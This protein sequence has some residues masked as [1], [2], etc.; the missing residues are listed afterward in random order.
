MTP[1]QRWTDNWT[2]PLTGCTCL[3]LLA[4]GVSVFLWLCWWLGGEPC[5]LLDRL[6]AALAGG[7]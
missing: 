1:I 6:F 3:L 4:V 2:D 7:T 5:P